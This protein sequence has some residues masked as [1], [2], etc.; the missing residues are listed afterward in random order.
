MDIPNSFAILVS[1]APATDNILIIWITHGGSGA[2]DNWNPIHR[3]WCNNS[4]WTIYNDNDMWQQHRHIE[5]KRNVQHR[6]NW[7]SRPLNR[8]TCFSSHIWA[9]KWGYVTVYQISVDHWLHPIFITIIVR[10]SLLIAVMIHVIQA[11]TLDYHSEVDTISHWSKTP[12][13]EWRHVISQTALSG[14]T[15]EPHVMT[16]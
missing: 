12:S 3:M 8:H 2:P 16:R 6:R 5:T 15:S 4:T 1:G 9:S 10:G 7:P 14:V 13:C 11:S